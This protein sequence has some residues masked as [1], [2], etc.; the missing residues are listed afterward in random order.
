MSAN[1][2]TIAQTIY[3]S[4]VRKHVRRSFP[5]FKNEV[6]MNGTTGDIVYIKESPETGK[7]KY[8]SV[9]EKG[10]LSFTYTRIQDTEEIERLVALCVPEQ[11]GGQNYG[12]R[13]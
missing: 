10:V 2:L 13:T 9:S 7:K 1:L 12:K 3:I 6:Y 8:Y 11:S 5:E 4:K